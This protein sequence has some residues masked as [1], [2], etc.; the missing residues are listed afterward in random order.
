V[1]QLKFAGIN[2]DNRDIADIIGQQVTSN[3]CSLNLFYVHFP[4]FL[5]HRFLKW[6]K[7]NEWEEREGRW[8][9]REGRGGNTPASWRA[10]LAEA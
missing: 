9:N 8:E 4:H 2:S 3:K 10:K 7:R 6:V 1:E 5:P